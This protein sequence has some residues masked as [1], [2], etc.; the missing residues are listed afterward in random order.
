MIVHPTGKF[1]NRAA[2]N[3][4]IE[5]RPLAAAMGAEIVGVDIAKISDDQFAEVRAA[6]FRH[7][8][9]YLRD[10]SIT[11][12]DQ[13]AF[14]RRFGPFAEDAY[15][16]GVPDHPDVQPL[17]KEAS[18][19]VGMVFG[20]GWHTDSAFLAE[21][22]A[23]SMLYA[24]EVPPYGGDTLWANSALA[25]AM[26]SP[27]MQAMIAPL[28]VRMSMGRVVET[29][30]THQQPD[31]TALGRVAATRTM[32]QLPDEIVRKVRGS[33][34]PLVRTHPVTGEK[35]LYCDEVYAAGIE[36]L[37]AAEAEPLLKFLAGHITQPAF[38]CR[39]RWAPGTYVAWDN[40]ICVHQA[41]N[42]YDGFRREL[43]RTTIA[44]E[45]PR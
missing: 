15:T 27:T 32:A 13:E 43:Y 29:A 42:D 12:A 36:G 45:A 30:Q 39:L 17:I 41:F 20:A 25:Y 14:S 40:R 19:E 33:V 2:A 44:G 21:P 28:K 18:E 5:V 26:L 9:I 10:Q 35:A 34:H 24:V 7:K 23:I 3:R 37:T 31:D 38:T 4:F 11:H 1:D 8:M 16:Q 22:P 6:L